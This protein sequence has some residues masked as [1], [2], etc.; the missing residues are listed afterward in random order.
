MAIDEW[1]IPT[2]PIRTIKKD[3]SVLK[4]GTKDEFK[5]LNTKISS[6]QK[7]ILALT[8]A[9]NELISIIKEEVKSPPLKR[10][11][12]PPPPLPPGRSL[13]PPNYL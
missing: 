2:E 3:V 13:P 11:K 4:D 1:Q 10:K 6:L 12:L 9:I 7:Q 5:K 8:N